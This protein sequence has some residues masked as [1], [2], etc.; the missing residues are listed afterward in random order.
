ML[1]VKIRPQLQACNNLQALKQ[2]CT[3][4]ILQRK[5]P[6]YVEHHEISI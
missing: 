3:F 2:P 4:Y 6:P 5:F 1:K